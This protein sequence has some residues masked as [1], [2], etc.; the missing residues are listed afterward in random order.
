MI[1][2]IEFQKMSLNSTTEKEKL[3]TEE[4]ILNSFK[5]KKNNWNDTILY[6]CEEYK[7]PNNVNLNA[8]LL[9]YRQM[10][11]D[12]ICSLTFVNFDSEKSIIMGKKDKHLKYNN[13][14]SWNERDSFINADLVVLIE[15]NTM[16][17]TYIEF[18]KETVKN[19][20]SLLNSLKNKLYINNLENG[21]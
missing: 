8:E 19:I 15:R 10:L 6:L 17:K 9:S 11:T 5:E 2:P 16:F 20:D 21:L 18:L 7:K 13:V 1:N 12:E 14:S 3:T 4:K